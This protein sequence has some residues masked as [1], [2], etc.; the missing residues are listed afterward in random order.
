M[1]SIRPLSATFG[2]GLMVFFYSAS[3]SSIRLKSTKKGRQI[4]HLATLNKIKAKMRKEK[5]KKTVPPKFVIMHL[6]ASPK[7]PANARKA[8]PTHAKLGLFLI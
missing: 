7:R 5:K 4:G 1:D 2:N 6:A 3:S 8:L